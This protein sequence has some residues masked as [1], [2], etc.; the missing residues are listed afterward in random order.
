[1]GAVPPAPKE[2]RLS[3]ETLSLG[4]HNPKLIE[5][6]K[7]IRHA[8]LTADGLLVAEGPKLIEEARRSGLEVVTVF[9]RRGAEA[10]GVSARTAVYELDPAVFKTIQS[11]ETSQ[12]VVA[13]VRPRRYDFRD[14]LSAAR[15]LIVVLSRLQDPGNAGTI[16]RVAESFGAT[17]CLATLGA[18]GVFNPKTLRASAGSVFR[19]PYVWDLDARELFRALKASNIRVVGTAPGGDL[20]IAEWDW[21]RPSAIVIGNEGGGLTSEEIRGCDAVVRIPHQATVESLNSAI[22]AAVILYEASK[23]RMS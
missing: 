7:A 11:T 17:A 9:K 19:L 1:M 21:H 13:L 3:L 12:G 10:P 15:P 18:A 6:R 4:K 22:A 2:L 23:Q 14:V 16:I 20:T 8:T 5:V